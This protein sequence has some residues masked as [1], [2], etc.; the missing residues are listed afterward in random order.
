MLTTC[1]K[2]GV[3]E[4]PSLWVLSGIAVRIGQKMNLHRDNP[5]NRGSVFDN[6]MRKRLWGQIIF[7]DT[8]AARQEIGQI[9]NNIGDIKLPLNV[10][11]TDLYPDMGHVPV[12]HT[13]PTEMIFCLIKYET[14]EVFLNSPHARALDGDVQK[15]GSTSI[16]VA[17][18]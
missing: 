16:S 15:L 5:S 2:L 6:E 13:G 12:E 4:T 1:L 17:S 11:D 14:R 8:R 10:N 18:K 9:L 7:L 3:H